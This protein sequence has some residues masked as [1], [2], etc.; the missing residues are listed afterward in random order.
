MVHS[1]TPAFLRLAKSYA[2]WRV[3][4]IWW[5]MIVLNGAH[6]LRLL[7]LAQNRCATQCDL[8]L[9]WGSVGIRECKVFVWDNVTWIEWNGIPL[10]LL[11]SPLRMSSCVPAKIL[12]QRSASWT[13]PCVSCNRPRLIK[14]KIS[15]FVLSFAFPEYAR[16]PAATPTWRAGVSLWLSGDTPKFRYSA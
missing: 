9:C 4:M 11:R 10:R 3:C 1:S 2:W 8:G 16:P 13:T 12:A 14:K 5:M 6:L 7:R 15:T